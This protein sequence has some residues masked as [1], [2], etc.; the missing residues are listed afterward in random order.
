MRGEKEVRR[1]ADEIK[2]YFGV[3]HCFLLS[4]GK[5]S[6][7]L[8]LQALHD[9]YPERD[10]VLIPAF[11]CYSVPSAVVRA[12]LKIRLCDMDPQSLGYNLEQLRKI[13]LQPG[14]A[15][16][17][18]KAGRDR[19]LAIVAAHLYGLPG[20]LCGLREIADP[21][22][23]SLIEDAAQVMG[24]ESCGRKYGTQGD[25]GFFSLGSGKSHLGHRRWNHYYQP[26]RYRPP[27]GRENAGY[28]SI[29]QLGNAVPNRANP[30]LG[31]LSEPE[32]VLGSQ[33]DSLSAVGRD[34]LR[35]FFPNS[36]TF[37]V[38][39][40][41]IQG[42]EEK[43]KLY[44]LEREKRSLKWASHLKNK[45]GVRLFSREGTSLAMVRF[46]VI[47]E[48]A[49]ARQKILSLSHENGPEMMRKLHYSGVAM[50]EFKINPKTN[51]WVFMEINGRFW[52][53]LPL[54]MAAGVDFPGTCMSF[55]FT[56]KENFQSLIG[57]V[58]TVETGLWISNGFGQTYRPITPIR[59]S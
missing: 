31:S 46:P 50:V 41:P 28:A 55:G 42:L 15:Q 57:R 4:S 24:G 16:K 59:C 45:R 37:S 34:C 11:T 52:G 51:E 25:V 30:S 1:F 17:E 23:I 10:E 49:V 56:G 9:L 38:S 22:G 7:T 35:P 47:L 53:S 48:D 6:L 19:I 32:L 2:R 5:A 39:S 58:Y 29:F 21:V 26:G 14:G 20:D 18:G 13:L 36:E 3:K 40:R 8:I 12:G 27:P 43:T 44:W 54:A 33:S